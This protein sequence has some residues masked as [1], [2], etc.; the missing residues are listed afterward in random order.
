[1]KTSCC[2]QMRRRLITDT[3]PEAQQWQNEIF[4]GLSGEEKVRLAMGFSDTVRDIAWAGFRRRHPA[5]SEEML[6]T[7]FLQEVHGIELPERA[8]IQSNESSV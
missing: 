5:V 7:L 8:K 6:R 1:M 4:E 2:C 3:T